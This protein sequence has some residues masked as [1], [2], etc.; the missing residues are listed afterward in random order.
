[1]AND[2]M[3][4]PNIGPEEK[5]KRVI[6]GT[7]VLFIGL[8]TAAWMV[9]SGQAQWTRLLLAV[10]FVYAGV[11][12]WQV[13][14]ETCVAF[15]AMGVRKLGNRPEKVTESVMDQAIR[16]Q[17]TGVWIRGLTTGALLTALAYFI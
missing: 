2:T 5:K 14:A 1:M 12:L 9:T 10:P 16:K 6:K 11:C 7:V 15:A 4:F 3:C 13:P 17:A 8:A